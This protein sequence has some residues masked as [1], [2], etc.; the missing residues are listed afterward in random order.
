MVR[1]ALRDILGSWIFAME[2]LT[3]LI[4]DPWEY[5]YKTGEGK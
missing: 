3:G 1:G 2:M 5:W 4:Y